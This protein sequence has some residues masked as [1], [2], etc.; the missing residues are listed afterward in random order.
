[1]TQMIIS[2]KCPG[3][4]PSCLRFITVSGQPGCLA[5]RSDFVNCFQ[6]PPMGLFVMLGVRLSVR[7]S[8]VNIITKKILSGFE[9]NFLS[10]F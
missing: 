5:V 3:A 2:D 10:W 1:M 7:L 9:R 4:P 8:S 6:P